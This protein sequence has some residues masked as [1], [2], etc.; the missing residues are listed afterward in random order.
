MAFQLLRVGVRL[1]LSVVICI[2]AVQYLIRSQGEGVQAATNEST[3]AFA[4]HEVVAAPQAAFTISSTEDDMAPSVPMADPGLADPG[5]APEQGVGSSPRVAAP[6]D[7]VATVPVKP[8]TPV[9]TAEVATNRVTPVPAVSIPPA[10]G[11]AGAETA[12]TDR[13][14]SAGVMDDPG[15]KPVERRVEAPGEF[16]RNGSLVIGCNEFEFHPAAILSILAAVDGQLPVVALVAD[17]K[18]EAEVRDAMKGA[19]I[20]GKTI[21][22]LRQSLDS[23]WVRDYGPLFVNHDGRTVIVRAS[24]KTE[25]RKYDNS[26]AWGLGV[27]FDVP[28]REI[29]LKLDAGNLISNGAG[30]L[31]SSSLLHTWNESRVASRENL[32]AIL[33]GMYGFKNIA[34]VEPL[35]GEPTGHADMFV[36]FLSPDLAVVGAFDPEIDA[37]NAAR[38]DRTAAKIA[39]MPCPAG[40]VRVVRIPM[41]PHDDELFRTYTNVVFANGTL[42]VPNYPNAAPLY[43]QQALSIYRKLLPDWNVVGIDSTTLIRKRGSLHCITLNV[44]EILRPAAD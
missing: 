41:P 10:T 11:S 5:L 29:P 34:L 2:A 32:G 12:P 18:N 16:A 28:V 33:N 7:A 22:F 40:K 37:E 19:G 38:L 24:Y 8:N 31:V 14:T 21:K 13:T 36:T 27:H 6:A 3:Q 17:E 43:D 4:Q 25:T 23:M 42:L 44:P 20:A 35:A 30:A 1:I 26:F 39:E 15:A 9:V